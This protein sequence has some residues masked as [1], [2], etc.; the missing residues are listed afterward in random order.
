MMKCAAVRIDFPIQGATPTIR[1]RKLPWRD[2]GGQL[3]GGK[4]HS[5]GYFDWQQAS[6]I[7]PTPSDDW[8]SVLLENENI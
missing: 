3:P 2:G 5:G 6:K 1:V 4:G 7:K 8:D